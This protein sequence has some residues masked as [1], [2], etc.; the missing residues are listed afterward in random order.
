MAATPLVQL[1]K[2]EDSRGRL[3]SVES[4]RDVPFAIAR[5][6]YILP[7]ESAARGF[8][9]HRTLEQLMICVSGSCRVILDDGETRSEWLLDRPDL[10]LMLEPMVWHE[11]HDLSEGSILLVLASARYDESDYIRDRGEF[12]REAAARA[13]R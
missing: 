4:L 8:H 9:A 10:G 2:H 6:Y 12:V 1:A 11:M 7:A 13:G 3:V 5:A